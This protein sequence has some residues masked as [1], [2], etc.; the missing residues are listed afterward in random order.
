LDGPV[1]EFWAGASEIL[2][3]LPKEQREIAGGWFMWTLR[4]AVEAAGHGKSG[5][6]AKAYYARLAREVNDLCDRGVLKAGPRRS[7][8]LPPPRKEYLGPF[9]AAA[10][11]AAWMLVSFDQMGTKAGESIGT[12]ENLAIFSRLTRGRLSPLPGS[13]SFTPK[14]VWRE[15]LRLA[16]LDRIGR[17]YSALAP[18][19]GGAALAALLAAGGIAIFRRRVSCFTFLGLALLGSIVALVLI[20]ALVDSTS[21]PAQNTGY[22]AGG[23]AMWLLLMFVGWLALAEGW[24]GGAAKPDASPPLPAES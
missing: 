4:E 1:G 12:P 8:F 22:L 19:V 23:Y 21:F 11:G 6:T 24:R 3:H 16:I 5:A 10:R 13:T 2:T 20:V 17:V 7:G 9:L 14:P 15:G 18:W